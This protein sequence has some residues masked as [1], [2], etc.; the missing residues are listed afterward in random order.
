MILFFVGIVEMLIVTS[1]TKAVTGSR[2]LMSGVITFINVLIWYYVLQTI[3]NN[4]NAWHVAVLYALGCAV[5]TACTTAY[6]WARERAEKLP[7]KAEHIV[8]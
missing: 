6:F 8:Q 5:G 2:V 4:V 7:A 1:W 3:V